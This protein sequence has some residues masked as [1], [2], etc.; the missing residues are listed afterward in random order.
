MDSHR[1]GGATARALS[2]GVDSGGFAGEIFHNACVRASEAYFGSLRGLQVAPTEDAAH[3]YGVDKVCVSRTFAVGADFCGHVNS[4]TIP[5]IV[6]WPTR[7]FRDIRSN[8]LLTNHLRETARL[9]I[10]STS[11]E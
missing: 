1:D 6:P 10:I 3:G 2:G 5:W 9:G 7:I 8:F 4:A 11:R